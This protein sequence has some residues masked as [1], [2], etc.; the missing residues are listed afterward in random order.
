MSLDFGAV[1]REWRT[2]RRLSQLELGLAADVSSRHISFLETGRARPSRGMVLRLCDHL[3]VPRA[4]RNRL[5]AAAGLAPAYA[6]RTLAA[7]ELAPLRDALDWMLTRHAPYPAFALDRHWYVQAMNP[8]ATTLFGAVGLGAGDSLLAALADDD[9]LRAALENLDAVVAAVTARLRSESGHLGG[10]PVLDAAIARFAATATSPPPA[11]E[12]LAPA[13]V[14]TRFRF[15]DRTLALVS[16]IAQFGA[17]DDMA[18][19]DW[20][21]ELLFPAD[22]AS[23]ELLLAL[24]ETLDGTP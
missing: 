19:A 24:P 16:T 1:L 21:I 10:D 7:D 11:D 17:V 6:A 22:A 20:R 14:A 4:A 15:G 3:E 9:R 13:F 2:R 12:G 23:R 8:P 18:L 5:L